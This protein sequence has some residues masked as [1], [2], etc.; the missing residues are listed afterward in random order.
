MP[1]PTVF[2]LAGGCSLGGEQR[3]LEAT[4]RRRILDWK[5]VIGLVFVG[6]RSEQ[7]TLRD[8]A[9]YGVVKEAV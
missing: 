1:V 9:L 6:P 3:A 8:S 7:E 4:E 5:M 2:Q